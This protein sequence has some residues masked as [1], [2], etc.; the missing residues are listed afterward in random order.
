LL[1]TLSQDFSHSSQLQL[2]LGLL[3]AI[4]FNLDIPGSH[5]KAVAAF[6][7]LMTLTPNDPQ[8]NY[9]YGAFVA[10]T[11]RKGEGIPFLEKA[12]ALGVQRGLLVG[13]EL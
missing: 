9:Q 10:A 1:D 3:H 5:E 7:T 8:A 2:R 13:V 4:G 11:T 6:S 12:K